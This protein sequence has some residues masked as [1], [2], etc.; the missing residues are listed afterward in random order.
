VAYKRGDQPRAQQLLQEARTAMRAGAPQDGGDSSV[1]DYLSI[2]IQ[3]A[4]KKYAEAVKTADAARQRFPFLRGLAR[5]Y[6][7]ALLAAGRNDEAMVYLRDQIQLYRQESALQEQLAQ[8]YSAQG[9]LAL[10]HVALAEAYAI[11]GGLHAAM[12][13]LR[14]ARK[15]P[16]A[17][18]YDQALIDARER[19][20][21]QRWRDSLPDNKKD[22]PL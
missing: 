16:D 13:Q 7:D 5:R 1:L 22:K 3:L 11:D 21:Q 12:D 6:A 19:D 2:D 20:L 4:A 10:Q 8:V 9:K 17:S 18:F 14:I 15:A